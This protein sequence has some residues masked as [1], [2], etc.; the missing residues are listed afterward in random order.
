MLSTGGGMTFL[1]DESR[2]FSRS[3]LGPGGLCSSFSAVRRVLF[4]SGDDRLLVG[5]RSISSCDFGDGS[6]LEDV[7]ATSSYGRLSVDAIE[8]GIASIWSSFLLFV[9]VSMVSGGSGF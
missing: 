2:P 9:G 3:L 4:R 6:D 7:S 1:G 8:A 5:A